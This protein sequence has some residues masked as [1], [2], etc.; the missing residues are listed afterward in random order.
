MVSGP[1]RPD[2]VE[3]AATMGLPDDDFES[4]RLEKESGRT[5]RLVQTKLSVHAGFSG[6]QGE[7]VF[8]GLAGL[9]R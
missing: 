3:E 5:A 8:G 9:V 2:W 1:A 4:I 6:N 7:W